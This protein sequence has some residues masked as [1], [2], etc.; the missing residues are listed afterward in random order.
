MPIRLTPQMRHLLRPHRHSGQLQACM[1][2]CLRALRDNSAPL[3]NTMDVFVA[4]PLLDWK[5]S[6]HTHLGVCLIVNLDP[7]SCRPMPGDKP[8]SSGWR[9]P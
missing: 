3:L 2:H 8:D 5:V 6:G 9:R 4:E 1:L 7:C